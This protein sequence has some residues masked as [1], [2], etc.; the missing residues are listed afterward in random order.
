MFLWLGAD[1]QEAYWQELFGISN[2]HELPTSVVRSIFWSLFRKLIKSACSA[3][4]L[5][6]PTPSRPAFER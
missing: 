3:N 5:N 1:V 4:S 2:A 6:Y